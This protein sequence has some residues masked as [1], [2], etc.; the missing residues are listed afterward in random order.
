MPHSVFRSILQG[1]PPVFGGWVTFDAIG[2]VDVLAGAGFDYLGIDTQHSM[3][4]VAGAIRLL[5]AIPGD[6]PPVLIRVP[7]NDAAAIAKVLDCGADGV[8]VPMVNTAEQAAAA[9]AACQYSPRGA[10][11]FGPVRRRIGRDIAAVEDRAACFVMVETAEA[12]ENIADIVAVTGVAG[13][14]VGPA[15]LAITMGLPPAGAPTP[16]ALR[17]AVRRVANH[18]RSAGIIA[19]IHGLSADHV[20]EVVADGY[21]LVT[22]V[23]DK[24]YLLSGAAALLSAARQAGLRKGD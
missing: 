6:A 16:T 2:L 4:D 21:T 19:G 13:V 23:A 15:D 17:E 5:Y 3:I 1:G 18:A 24:A 10:R 20:T 22:L 11:S 14:Y 8:I 9:V 12:V 7:S